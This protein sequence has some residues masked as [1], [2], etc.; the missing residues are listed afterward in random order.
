MVQFHVGGGTGKGMK[1]GGALLEMLGPGSILPAETESTQG[2][3]C[4]TRCTLVI[5]VHTAVCSLHK[6]QSSLPSPA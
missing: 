3:G 5:Q 1:T 4:L 2:A 6:H